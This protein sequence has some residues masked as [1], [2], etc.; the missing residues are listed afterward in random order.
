MTRNHHNP[1]RGQVLILVVVG[2]VAMMGFAALAIDGGMTLSDR[3]NDQNAADAAALAGGKAAGVYMQEHDIHY[4]TF[5]CPRNLY[6]AH[7]GTLP[8]MQLSPGLTTTAS[9]SRRPTHPGPNNVWIE[10]CTNVMFNQHF[11]VHVRITTTTQTSFMHFVNDGPVV[12]TVDA[13][14]RVTPPKDYGMGNTVVAL[15]TTCEGND[16]GITLDGTAAR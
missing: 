13:V 4:E 12:N 11:D 7:S 2:M 9:P 5:T 16:G 1:E 14:V 3:R 8:G 6:L 10:N 15:R